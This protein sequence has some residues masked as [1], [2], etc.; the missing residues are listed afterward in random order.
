MAELKPCPYCRQQKPLEVT[1]HPII[2]VPKIQ[3]M[4][5]KYYIECSSCHWCGATKRGIKR[6][7]KAWNR[8]T[9]NE[10]R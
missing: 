10:H 5:G 4:F 2:P 9:T 1:I 3:R 7:I 8:G 6:A